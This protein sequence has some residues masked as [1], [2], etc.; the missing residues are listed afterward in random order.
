[1]DAD[2]RVVAEGKHLRRGGSPFRAHGV[3]YGSFRRRADGRP[4]PERSVM[5]SDF[6]AFRRWGIDTI[7]TYE[8]PPKDLLDLAE[9]HSIHLFVG[10]NY[11]DWRMEDHVGWTARRRIAD[12]GR[13]AVDEA[14]GVLAD[15]RQTLAVAVGN[16]IPVDLVRLHGRNH[17]EDGL[18][19]LIDQIHAGAPELLATYVNYPSTEFLDIPNQDIVSFNVFLERAEDFRRYISH[20]QMLSGPRPLVISEVGL[21]SK[22]HGCE[23]QAALLCNQLRSVDECGLAG[24]FVFA[25][26][27]DWAVGD[28]PVDGW[29]FGITTEQRCP[30]PGLIAVS[31]WSARPFPAGLRTAWPRISAVVCAYNEETTIGACVDSVLSSTYPNLELIVCDDGSTD[32]TAAIVEGR[33]V[34]LLR[35]D[36]AGLSNARNAGLAAATGDIVAFLDADAACHPHWPF[37]L[38]L[39]LEDPVAATGGPN[40][41]VPNA[42]LVERAISHV[43]GQASEVLLGRDRAEHVPGCNMAFRRDRL[44]EIGGFDDRYTSAGDDLDVCWK[45]HD[46][47]LEIGF[48]PAAQILHHRRSTVRGFLRQQ[49]GYGRAERMLSGPHRHRLNVLRQARWRG[50]IYGPGLFLPSLLKSSVYTGWFG[51]AS[52][53]PAITHR[54]RGFGDLVM[55]TI[56]L[57]AAFGVIG[58]LAGALFAPML[59]VAGASLVWLAVVVAIAGMSAPLD[60]REPSVA[61]MRILIGVLTVLQPLARTWGRVQGRPLDGAGSRAPA[62]SGDRLTWITALEERLRA[63]GVRVTPGGLGDFWDLEVTDRG[64]VSGRVVTAVAWAWEPRW[65]VRYRIRGRSVPV[66]ILPVFAGAWAGLPWGLAAVTIVAGVVVFSFVRTRHSIRTALEDTAGVAQR[67]SVTERP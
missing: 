13:R 7:R 42:G 18:G 43:P 5:C 8:V 49:V 47:G 12:A 40:L 6:A 66:V 31:E 59:L 48:S 29:G 32:A 67:R 10:L 26:T 55:V 61:R 35:L 38:A 54:A 3:T 19:E 9:E 56:P 45:L 39:S 44:L 46:A 58:L 37:H 23:A 11:H 33:G 30:K 21:A 28:E 24:A 62:W 36:H 22:I 50:F 41:P 65:A 60:H 1:M 25:W 15:T 20:L 2:G 17:V 53:Q 64:P 63:L 14:L 52:Y 57:V 34:A 4:F 16:E 27:D 51:S